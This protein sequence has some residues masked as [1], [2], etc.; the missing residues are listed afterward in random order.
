[1][2]MRSGSERENGSAPV[3]SGGGD[4]AGLPLT[5]AWGLP[6]AWQPLGVSSPPAPVPLG[7]LVGPWPGELFMNLPQKRPG[8]HSLPLG[9]VEP[10]IRI[11]PPIVAGDFTHRHRHE[12][13]GWEGAQAA[14]EEKRSYISQRH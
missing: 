14:G 13:L 9:C 5:A 6:W 7:S 10:E 1:M 12:C 3:G 11:A 4:R 2:G 8:T